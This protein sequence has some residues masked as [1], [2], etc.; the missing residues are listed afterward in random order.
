LVRLPAI[1]VL[2]VNA[3]L[4]FPNTAA[5]LRTAFAE[6]GGITGAWLIEW[7]DKVVDPTGIVPVQLELGGREKGVSTRFWGLGLRRFSQI[8]PQRIVDAPPITHVVDAN[9]GHQLVL[10]G[11]HVLENGDLL[12]FWQRPLDAGNPHAEYQIAGQT[13]TSTGE[14]LVRLAD[15]RPADYDYPVTRWPPSA[16]VMG[17]LP[18]TQWLG[19]QPTPGTYTLQLSVYTVAGNQLETL[20]TDDGRTTIDLPVTI[21]EFD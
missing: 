1:D 13:L 15:Q 7:Q 4:D 6:A 17:Q 14:T 10:R 2:D 12:L 21:T 19:A 16:V 5:P 9:F 11:Y 8:R 3:V 20:M 18:A